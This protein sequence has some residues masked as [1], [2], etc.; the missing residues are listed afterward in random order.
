MN[1]VSSVFL[2]RVMQAD[3]MC[4]WHGVHGD[5]V[6]LK[7]RD[8]L[9]LLKFGSCCVTISVAVAHACTSEDDMSAL[10]HL[11]NEFIALKLGMPNHTNF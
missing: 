9:D 6:E 10:E 11:F 5:R 7:N 1:S 8:S 4:N 2:L 3:C